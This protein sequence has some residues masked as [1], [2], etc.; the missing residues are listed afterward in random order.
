MDDVG[1]H[2]R[3]G[4]EI[5]ILQAPRIPT[6]YTFAT[7]DRQI[8]FAVR[9]MGRRLCSPLSSDKRLLALGGVLNS[10]GTSKAITWCTAV[11]ET[12]IPSMVLVIVCKILLPN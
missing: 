8:S 11:I 10:L 2:K 7:G 4:K 5:V 12:Y 3:L 6:K 1:M 9:R